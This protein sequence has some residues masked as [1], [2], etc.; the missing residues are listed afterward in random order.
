MAERNGVRSTSGFFN[1]DHAPPFVVSAL[2]ADAVRQA[3]LMALRAFAEGW[4][5]QKIVRAALALPRMG[6]SA[7]WIRHYL[8]GALCR[9]PLIELAHPTAQ[10]PCRGY[11]DRL[12]VKVRQRGPAAVAVRGAAGAGA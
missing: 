2:G 3:L 7:F 12:L 6:M 9:L 8:S 10:K 1:F 4:R 11:L 5:G